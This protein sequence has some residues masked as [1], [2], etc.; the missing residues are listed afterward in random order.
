MNEQNMKKEETTTVNMTLIFA[1]PKNCQNHVILHMNLS[2]IKMSRRF[3]INQQTFSLKTYKNH[4]SGTRCAQWASA[5]IS[6]QNLS[7]IFCTTTMT[8]QKTCKFHQTTDFFFRFF[9]WN[10]F[11]C[12]IL[13]Y[14][15][16][17][18]KSFQSNQFIMFTLMMSHWF[19]YV[20]SQLNVVHVNYIWSFRNQI[21]HV[22]FW[23]YASF[24]EQKWKK[25]TPPQNVYFL[26]C[27]LSVLYRN[28][29]VSFL[30]RLSVF[31]FSSFDLIFCLLNFHYSLFHCGNN[32]FKCW[33]DRF[34]HI[35]KI[36]F[37][38]GRFPCVVS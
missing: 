4:F 27:R 33:W 14:L 28:G 16:F 9:F 10:D 6:E 36:E 38:F 25:K 23:T 8:V 2:K 34:F 7:I 29:F 31:F 24:Y 35:L 5:C 30:N 26:C 22:L 18:F 3:S 21:F 20:L 32:R 11:I 13:Y 17:R 37:I 15:F 1:R 19:T 12:F